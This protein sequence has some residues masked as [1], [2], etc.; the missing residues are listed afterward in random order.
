MKKPLEE[1]STEII[2]EELRSRKPLKH[3]AN[4]VRTHLG[5]INLEGVE[6]LQEA[7]L[8]TKE[9]MNRAYDVEVFYRNHFDKV[10]KL[11]IQAQLEWIGTEVK[12]EHALHFGRG[13][14]NGLFLIREWFNKRV[15]E[16]TSRFEKTEPSVPG[17]PISPTGKFEQ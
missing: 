10:L 11:F 16:S 7:R 4:I 9:L 8:T 17:E 12:D 14:L 6:K 5:S 15:N 13:T 1:Q 2:L 3:S